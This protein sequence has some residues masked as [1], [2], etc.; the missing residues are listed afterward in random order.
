QI[1]VLGHFGHAGILRIGVSSGFCRV[2]LRP[3]APFLVS[4]RSTSSGLQL[5]F[6]VIGLKRIRY[7]RRQQ[8][9]KDSCSVR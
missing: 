3:A 4:R 5:H 1:V 2:R 8:N 6:L 9:F 7:V